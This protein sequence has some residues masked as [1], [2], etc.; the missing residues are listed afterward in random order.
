MNL[1]ISSLKNKYHLFSEQ[2]IAMFIGH[3]IGAECQDFI[4]AVLVFPMEKYVKI[5]L[6]ILNEVT[7]DDLYF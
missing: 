4:C 6:C 1:E 2:K 3:S 5:R 7:N